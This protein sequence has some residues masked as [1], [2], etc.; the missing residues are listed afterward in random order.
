MS[1]SV[2]HLTARYHRDSRGMWLVELAEEP[3]VRSFG[4][5]LT[6]ARAAILVEAAH[7]AHVEPN[8]LQID[9]DI[10]LPESAATAIEAA[11]QKRA[12]ADAARNEAIALTRSAAA[13][14]VNVQQLTLRDTADLLGVSPSLV[15]Q[16]LHD[17]STTRR[18]S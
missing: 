5:R 15:A 17:T 9:D 13:L 4:K 6:L 11:R 1:P 2:V 7:W 3:S 16:L 12:E 8:D 14:L 18:S 10:D